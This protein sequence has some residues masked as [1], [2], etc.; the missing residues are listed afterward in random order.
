VLLFLAKPRQYV[1]EPT[2]ALPPRRD[3][4]GLGSRG[5]FSFV[6]VLASSY[7]SASSD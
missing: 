3:L 1:A 7:F 2:H 5:H 4:S 6:L